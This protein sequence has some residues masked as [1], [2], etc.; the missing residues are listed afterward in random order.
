ML[1]QFVIVCFLVILIAALSFKNEKW[2]SPA[3]KV[4][5][6]YLDKAQDFKKQTEVLYQLI[7]KENNKKDARGEE[8]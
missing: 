8:G 2:F 3:E 1:R 4:K 5:S 6:F 7:K